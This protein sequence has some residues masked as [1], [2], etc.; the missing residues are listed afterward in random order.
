M[1]SMIP[2]FNQREPFVGNTIIPDEGPFLETSNLIAS[3]RY[4][5]SRTFAAC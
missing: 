2:P 5:V 1:I 3:L 4:V